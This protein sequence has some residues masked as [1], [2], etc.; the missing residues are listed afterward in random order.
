MNEY[1]ECPVSD[2]LS[3]RSLYT[4][5]RRR[6]ESDYIFCGEEHDFAEAVCVVGGRAGVTAGKKVYLLSEGSLIIHA[7]NEF[8]KI[9]SDGEEVE[10]VIFSFGS[11]RFPPLE[12]AVFRL[13]PEQVGE[14]KNIFGAAEKA[15]VL[16]G[17]NVKSVR[18]GRT[19]DASAVV[20]RLELFLL[21]VLSPETE[22]APQYRCR[23]AENYIRIVS[24]MERNLDKSLDA[25][26]LAG[27]CNLSVSALE[28][29]VHRYSGLG[30]M[31]FYNNLRMKRACELL[32]EGKSVKS[33]SLSLGYS[34]QNYFSSAFKKKTGMSPSEYR[35]NGQKE[36]N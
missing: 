7:P 34:C 10:T 11:E 23:S 15:F 31:S 13:S 5:S 25:E 9:W 21:S 32:K 29:T 36:N 2:A 17:A 12:N 26:K 35:R 33:V 1:R 28:K 20:K 18:E 8:H 14:L 30:L 24:L 16:D 6:F 4:F 22:T 27:L 19:N 3:I